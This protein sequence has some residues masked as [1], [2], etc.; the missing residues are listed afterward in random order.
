MFVCVCVCVC[1]F[2][3]VFVKFVGSFKN[4]KFSPALK[5]HLSESG[6][7]RFSY[8]GLLLLTMDQVI[9]L[10]AS[11]VVAQS[12]GIILKSS[13]QYKR[14]LFKPQGEQPR[15]LKRVLAQH[16]NFSNLSTLK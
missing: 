15:G 13:P 6:G 3:C 16:S 9:E 8:I 5:F 1:V 12:G 10:T 7:T 4:T 2:V 11:D 14:M